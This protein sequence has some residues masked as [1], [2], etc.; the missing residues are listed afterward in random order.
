MGWQGGIL[1]LNGRQSKSVKGT[2]ETMTNYKQWSWCTI[3]IQTSI[4]H[5]QT[6]LK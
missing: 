4:C 1:N 2:E 6:G 5:I 3:K